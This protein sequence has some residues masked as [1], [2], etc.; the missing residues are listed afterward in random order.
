MSD[1]IIGHVTDSKEGPMDG[2]YAETKGTY[3]KFKGTGAFQKDLTEVDNKIS[4]IVDKIKILKDNSIASGIP[5][6][7]FTEVAN[8]NTLVEKARVNSSANFDKNQSAYNLAQATNAIETA[9]T[10]YINAFTEIQR[11][12]EE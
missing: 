3:T 11:K 12:R 4:D 2:V 7:N 10:K 5:I 9:K 1:F 8:A 6:N